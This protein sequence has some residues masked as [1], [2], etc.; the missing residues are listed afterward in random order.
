VARAKPRSRL[1]ARSRLARRARTVAIWLGV[2][3]AIGGIFYGLANTSTI[4]YGERQLTA[5]D[6]SSLTSDQKHSALV[7]ANGARCTCGCGMTL[8]QCVATDMT[9]P[10]R[11]D[12]IT[13]IRGMVQKALNSGG[14]S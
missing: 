14:G 8:A 6:F 11:T 13:K 5:I 4:A 7:E 10:V 3:A 12:N 2:V 9:C 1:G